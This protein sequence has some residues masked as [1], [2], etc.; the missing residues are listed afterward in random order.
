M[1]WHSAER[2]GQGVVMV[3]GA[4]QD[5]V[6]PESEWWRQPEDER[7]GAGEICSRGGGGPGRGVEDI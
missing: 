2:Q 7:A 6:W 4:V 1:K 5:D 3:V